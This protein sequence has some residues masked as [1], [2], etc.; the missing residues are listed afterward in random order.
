MSQDMSQ[1]TINLLATWHAICRLPADSQP[2]YDHMWSIYK[3]LT[4]LGLTA[5]T[6]ESLNQLESKVNS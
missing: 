2:D 1:D 3:Q 6:P 4:V 5:F